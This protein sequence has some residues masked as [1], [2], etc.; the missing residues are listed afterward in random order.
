M[1][2]NNLYGRAHHNKLPHV[3]RVFDLFQEYERKWLSKG[4][5]YGWNNLLVDLRNEVVT[6]IDEIYQQ[7]AIEL[8]HNFSIPSSRRKP[9]L[10]SEF[11]KQTPCEICG[12]SKFINKSHI[13]PKELGGSDA[14]ENIIN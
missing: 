3:K 8:R 1:P 6:V 4:D 12:K 11:P 13:I 7:L 10:L 14:Y 2:N 5:T 9:I